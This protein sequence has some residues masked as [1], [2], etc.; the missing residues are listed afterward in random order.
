[1]HI[2]LTKAI[3]NQ[4]ADRGI[5]VIEFDKSYVITSGAIDQARQRGVTLKQVEKANLEAC[6][7]ESEVDG[8]AAQ[9]VKAAIVARL[10]YAPPE[11]DAIIQGV[12]KNLKK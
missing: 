11:L 4:H 10:G 5:K 12:L 2:F 8:Q 3:I 7:A 1:M 6:H 9:A